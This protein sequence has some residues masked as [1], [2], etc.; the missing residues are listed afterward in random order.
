MAIYANIHGLIKGDLLYHTDFS[1]E[2]DA[3][4]TKVLQE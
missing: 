1:T 4:L 2:V 3:S